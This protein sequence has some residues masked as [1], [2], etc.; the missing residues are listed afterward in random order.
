MREATVWEKIFANL[1]PGKDLYVEYKSSQNPTLRKQHSSQIGKGLRHFTKEN[2]QM[3][4]RHMR[5]YSISLAS[6]KMPIR[7]LRSHHYRLIR[8]IKRRKTDNTQCWWGQRS[9]EHPQP[10]LGLKRGTVTPESGWLPSFLW[11]LPCAS[12]GCG[13]PTLGIYPKEWKCVFTQKPVCDCC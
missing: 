2:I 8:M 6:R 10:M 5:R 3:A 9:L 13:N 11:H 12:V 7:A 1:I 4:N